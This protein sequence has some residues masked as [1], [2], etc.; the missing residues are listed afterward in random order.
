MTPGTIT[1]STL[2]KIK[3]RIGP[4]KKLKPLD[5]L[6][7]KRGDI[8]IKQYT[9]VTHLG[10]ELDHTLSGESMVTKVIGKING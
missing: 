4:Q 7:I 8:E 1:P 6:V 9:K 5:H 10:C 2:E 3:N